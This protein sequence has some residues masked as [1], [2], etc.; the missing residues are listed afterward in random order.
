MDQADNGVMPGF[1]KHA[2]EPRQHGFT[3]LEL[4]VVVLIMGLF[5]GL[6]SVN[7]QPDERHQLEVETRRLARLLELVAA[8]ARVSG[9]SFAWSTEADAYHFLQLNPASGWLDVHDNDTL[10]PRR[11]PT[12]MRISSLLVENTPVE[13]PM[14]V[15][16]PAYGQTSAF[17]V[18]LVYGAAISRVEVSPIGAVSVLL[19]EAEQL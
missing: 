19:D 9:I 15:E 6:V 13:E 17:T 7:L 14:R 1:P 5:V 10:R 8:E 18:V 12:G 11:L 16:F 4:M 2:R 3:L